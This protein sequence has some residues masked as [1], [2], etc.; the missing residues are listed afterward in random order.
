[1]SNI[2]DLINAIESGKTSDIQQHF[3]SIMTDKM[4]SAIE[5][6][7]QFIASNLFKESVQEDT[8]LVEELS[9]LDE[10]ELEEF[11]SELDES[12]IQALLQHVE[13]SEQLDELSKTT[14]GNY[15]KKA[16]LDI[17]NNAF[18]SGDK[19]ARGDSKGMAKDFM[20]SYKRQRGTIRAANKLAESELFGDLL[21]MDETQF[22]QFL[23]G[24]DEAEIQA[25]IQYIGEQEQLDELSKATLGSYAKKAS[26]QAA[27]LATNAMHLK[28][29]ADMHRDLSSEAPSKELRKHSEKMEK[30]YSKHSFDATEK[31]IKRQRGVAKAIDRLTK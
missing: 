13:E 22:D 24:L 17:H 27:G 6:R 4:V 15:I 19:H 20:A 11:L 10:S 16:S 25:L 30:E 8:N 23:S 1:M 18:K 28:N 29:V 31:Q 5:E 7:K 3:H 9:Q 21:E 26:A 2:L 12:E 14:L